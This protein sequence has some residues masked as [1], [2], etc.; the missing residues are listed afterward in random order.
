MQFW[1]S[2]IV[3]K[4]KQQIEE[5]ERIEKLKS[6]ES[7]QSGD[8]QENVPSL[9]KNQIP[10]I[11]NKTIHEEIE[12]PKPKVDSTVDI[13]T[14]RKRNFSLHAHKTPHKQEEEEPTFP[15]RQKIRK[16]SLPL[17]FQPDTSCS[18]LKKEEASL[19]LQKQLERR[20]RQLKLQSTYQ[21]NL[22]FKIT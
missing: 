14:K 10:Q 20:R 2:F 11:Q 8:T 13:I 7:K 17:G 3:K 1:K 18:K 4:E 9:R 16:G 6:K 12:S 15:N 22:T 21:N 5:Q 19:I